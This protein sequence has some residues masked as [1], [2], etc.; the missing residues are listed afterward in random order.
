MTTDTVGGVWTYAIEL[1]AALAEY[2]IEVT[3]ATMGSPVS[4]AQ[5]ADLA[6]LS[7]TTVE[8]SNYRLEWMDDPWADV[9][10]AGEWLLQL[11]AEVRPDIVHLNGYAHAALPW[12]APTLVVGHSCVYSW[13]DAVHRT[14]PPASWQRYFTEVQRGLRRATAVTAPSQT[15][16]DALGHHYGGFRRVVPIP[17]ARR[18]H[19]FPPQIKEPYIL[20]A[21]RLWD[22]A[23]NIRALEPIATDLAWPVR[24]AGDN[25][26][27][28]AGEAIFS[29]RMLGKLDRVS[30]ARQMGHASIFAHPARYEPFGLVALEAALAGC[31]LVLGDIPSL[32]EVWGDAALFVDP[33]DSAG[34]R[35]T[36]EHLIDDPSERE[37]YARRARRKALSYTPAR[38][39][40]SYRLL[41]DALAGTKTRPDVSRSLFATA[42]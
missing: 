25:I 39:R 7:N 42:Q 36:L 27:P 23:K 6:E 32:R 26:H 19:L 40:R 20:A 34:L 5:R 35:L 37:R 11:E 21:G 17:N 24:L 18:S 2:D 30:L 4:D 33:G 3:L 10:A 16:L 8:T 13:F 31:A 41:Y 12:R 28:D 22:E 15:M 38:M 29:I 1:A 9:K 14:T